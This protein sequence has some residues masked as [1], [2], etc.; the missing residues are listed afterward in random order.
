MTGP[1]APGAERSRLLVLAGPTAV[2]KGPVAADIRAHH[3]EV[4]ISVSATT[5]RPR[6][7][8]VDGVHY[9]FVS[10][11]R[12]DEVWAELEPYVAVVDEQR[13]DCGTRWI[14]RY[15]KQRKQFQ[16]HRSRIAE[17]LSGG[18]IGV[19]KACDVIDR[20]ERKFL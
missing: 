6:P 18:R 2:G 15:V 1:A 19:W 8:E 20:N 16:Y 10:D 17:F 14:D 7:G 11:E 9:W 13:I 3:P 4:W 5:R 12:F